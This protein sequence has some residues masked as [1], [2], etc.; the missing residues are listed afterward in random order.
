MKN[1]IPVIRSSR[2]VS[3]ALPR[4][5][6]VQQGLNTIFKFFGELTPKAFWEMQKYKNRSIYEKRGSIV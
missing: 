5:V 1:T 2:T 4:E 3:P 6:T